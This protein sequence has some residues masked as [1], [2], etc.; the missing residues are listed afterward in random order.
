M[1]PLTAG[2]LILADVWLD[3]P[4]VCVDR[5][6]PELLDRVETGDEL[7]VGGDGVVTW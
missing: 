5:L 2:G 7:R 3:T 6:G 4:I 1:D